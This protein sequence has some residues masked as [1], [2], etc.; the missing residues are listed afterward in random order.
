MVDHRSTNLPEFGPTEYPAPEPCLFRIDKKYFSFGK[1]GYNLA[2]LSVLVIRF[3]V[4]PLF[5]LP[6]DF[7]FH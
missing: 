2:T 1:L 4:R 3:G 6:F 5:F 7:N